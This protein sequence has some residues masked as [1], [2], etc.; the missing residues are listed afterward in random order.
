MGHTCNDTHRPLLSVV[1]PAFRLL[2]RSEAALR[3]LESQTLDSDDYKVIHLDDGPD[4]G[5]VDVF[6]SLRPG[7]DRRVVQNHCN[8]GHA[9]T[10]TSGWR[11]IRGEVIGFLDGDMIAHP[12]LLELPWDRFARDNVDVVS[13]RRWCLNLNRTRLPRRF[14]RSAQSGTVALAA[15][16]PA[17]VVLMPDIEKV[18]TCVDVMIIRE[19][20]GRCMRKFPIRNPAEAAWPGLDVQVVAGEAPVDIRVQDE[21]GAVIEIETGEQTRCRFVS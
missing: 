14:P 17:W 9:S 20:A 3:H 5:T 16:K 15:L 13:G 7:L 10:R 21:I 6:N 8:H 4:D 19:H 12:R 1:I 11:H 2:G 18:R